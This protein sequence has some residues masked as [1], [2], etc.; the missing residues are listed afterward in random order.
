VVG[1]GRA[2]S[3]DGFDIAVSVV[4]DIGADGIA[5]DGLPYEPA[6][7]AGQAK[8]TRHLERGSRALEIM[9]SLG[10]Y[11][12]DV[13]QRLAAAVDGASSGVDAAGGLRVE[14]LDI[15][16]GVTLG[17]GIAA[18]FTIQNESSAQVTVTLSRQQGSGR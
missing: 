16:F 10:E 2:R 15:T 14:S 7:N 5:V 17:A 13:S 8:P 6:S 12:G 4:S 11:I 3:L 18:L 9:D 1:V